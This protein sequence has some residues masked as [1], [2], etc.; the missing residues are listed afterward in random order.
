M[1]QDYR[2][3][4]EPDGVQRQEGPGE[5]KAPHPGEQDTSADPT[6]APLAHPDAAGDVDTAR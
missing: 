3:S 6:A 4:H 1:P 2:T 5:H